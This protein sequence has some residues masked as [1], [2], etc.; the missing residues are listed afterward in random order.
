MK[1]FIGFLASIAL[2]ILVIFLVI[3][4]FSGGSDTTQTTTKL[5][6]YA[7]TA[8]T[9]SLTVDGPINADETHNALRITVGRDQASIETFEGYEEQ[10]ID[11]RDYENNQTS[12]ANFLRALDIAGFTKGDT[13]GSKD[14]RGECAKKDRFIL[15]IKNGS[16]TRQ[17]FWTTSCGG[18]TF[19]GDIADIRQLFIRQI[20]E[21]TT[22]TRQ[23]KL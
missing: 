6:T 9:V 23:L 13:E 11:S 17:K 5:V 21:Y 4:G 16:D 18:G 1:Y 3:R 14:P 20:P 7:D 2:V 22:L 10:V 15:E 8:T 12:Y 19:K